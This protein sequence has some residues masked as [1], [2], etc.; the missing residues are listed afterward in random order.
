MKYFFSHEK[1][2]IDYIK[3][4]SITFREL[5]LLAREYRFDVNEA[6]T[7]LGKEPKKRSSPSTSDSSR[8]SSCQSD[9]SN[10][11]KKAEKPS[12]GVKRGPSGY[13]LY[14]S[15]TGLSVTEASKK[16]KQLS[17]SERDNWKSK[18]KTK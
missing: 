8:M 3:Y 16:W 14:V 7:F 12:S 2:L 17:E 13:N 4:M 11:K 18:A 10:S 1:H 15:S 5:E 9:K 6:R